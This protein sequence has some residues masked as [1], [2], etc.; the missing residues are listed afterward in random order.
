MASQLAV[1]DYLQKHR[2]G[3]L[4]E[5]LMAKV[6]SDM[7]DE[8]C[9]YLSRV[10]N[11]RAEKKD[12]GLMRSGE[13]DTKKGTHDKPWQV[14]SKKLQPTVKDTAKLRKSVTLPARPEFDHRVGMKTK[15]TGFEDLWN[16]THTGKKTQD[17]HQKSRSGAITWAD[18][19]MDDG[20]DVMFSAYGYKGPRGKRYANERRNY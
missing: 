3:P 14:N 6:I 19:N 17:T 18:G 9:L 20:E 7:P 11:I 1:Q 2:I 15:P 13:H 10:L 16:D 4:F 12:K 8:P 5:E